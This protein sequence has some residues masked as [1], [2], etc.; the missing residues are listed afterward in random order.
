MRVRPDDRYIIVIYQEINDHPVMPV[1][2][3]EVSEP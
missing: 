1:T 2:A 3:Y